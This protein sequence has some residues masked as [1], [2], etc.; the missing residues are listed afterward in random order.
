MRLRYPLVIV[1]LVHVVMTAVRPMVSYRAITLGASA[2]ELGLISAS[3]AVLSV[4]GAIPIGKAIDRFGARWFIVGASGITAVMTTVLAFTDSIV[5]LIVTQALIGVA[6]VTIAIGFQT[7]VANAGPISTSEGRFGI[8]TVVVSFGQLLGPVV[9][10]AVSEVASAVG[11]A[12]PDDPYATTP[13]FLV[14]A[15]FASLAFAMSLFI[16]ELRPQTVQATSGGALQDVGLVLKTRSLPSALFAS[17]VVLCTIDL[18]G[19]YLPLYGATAGLSVGFV[20]ALLATRAAA[21]LLVRLFMGRLLARVGRRAMLAVG[22]LL[23]AACLVLLPLFGHPV[24]L[25]VDMA[26]LGLVLGV[27]Q[28]LTMAWVA[29]SAPVRLR[30]TA[31]AIRLTANRL[32]Q[33]VI[34]L[35]AGL[36][37]GVAGTAAMFFSLGGLLGLTAVFVLRSSIDDDSGMPREGT[38]LTP[39]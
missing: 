33:F 15:G 2:E 25:L 32:G 31:L 14:I 24:A 7:L 5:V 27:G 11:W 20:S 37:A 29:R 13:V 16:R 18:L 35:G 39:Q 12:G 34:P 4:V 6:L 3:F 17:L 9:A 22:S 28:P 8:F 21:S 36:I 19:I 1:V 26:L 10:G 38:D 23:G 30:S